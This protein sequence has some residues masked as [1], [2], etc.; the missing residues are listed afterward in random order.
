MARIGRLVLHRGSWK[1]SQLVSAEEIRQA[2]SK[3]VSTQN[4]TRQT[5][6]HTAGYGY[7]FWRNN[8]YDSYRAYGQ[9]M[10]IAGEV[11]DWCY[12]ALTEA[13]KTQL[14]VLCETRM[15][16]QL[17]IGC[18]PNRQGSVTGHGSEAPILRGH[19][20]FAIAVYDEH[21]TSSHFVLWRVAT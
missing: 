15:M 7:F 8:D 2:T 17:E 3:Q 1:G 13:E 11:Y 4:A 12:D 16:P 9:V 14:V 18:P 19:P 10:L 5:P 20:G 21:P 6:D